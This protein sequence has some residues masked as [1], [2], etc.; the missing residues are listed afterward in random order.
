MPAHFDTG[1]IKRPSCIDS[2][3]QFTKS[4][5]SSF[6]PGFDLRE[7]ADVNSL[8]EHGIGGDGGCLF[9]LGLGYFGSCAFELRRHVCYADFGAAL[10]EDSGCCEAEAGCSS[11][12]GEDFAGKRCSCHFSF[13]YIWCFFSLLLLLKVVKG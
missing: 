1:V 4:V 8:C 2:S 13:F 10:D 3:V 6:E 12:D 11:S 5:D 7:V 9:F